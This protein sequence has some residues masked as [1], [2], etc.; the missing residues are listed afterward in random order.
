MK[1]VSFTNKVDTIYVSFLWQLLFEKKINLYLTAKEGCQ[2]D[3]PTSAEINPWAKFHFFLK[4][5]KG[6]RPLKS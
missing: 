1:A 6:F 3:N 2:G 4:K 5:K